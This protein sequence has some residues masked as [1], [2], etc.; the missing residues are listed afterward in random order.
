[1]KGGTISRRTPVY[2]GK[3]GSS[4]RPPAPPARPSG[5]GKGGSVRPSSGKGGSVSRPTPRPKPSVRP[6]SGKGGSVRPSSG[7]GG[8]IV[9]GR[10]SYGTNS[11]VKSSMRNWAN[12]IGSRRR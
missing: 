7:K 8:S 9:R 10:D 3:G 6:S 11:A 2:S 12:A 4:Y 1:M 5:G